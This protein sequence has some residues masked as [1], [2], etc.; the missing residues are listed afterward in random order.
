M[1]QNRSLIIALKCRTRNDRSGTRQRAKFPQ[2]E[3]MKTDESAAQKRNVP[4][5]RALFCPPSRSRR[6]RSRSSP[7]DRPAD[8]PANRP[9]RAPAT[10]AIAPAQSGCT[11]PAGPSH[12]DNKAPSKITPEQARQLFALVDV[13]IKFSSDET[14]LPIKSTVKRQLTTRDAVVKYL[15]EKFNEDEGTKRL[16]RDE[17]ILKKFGLL[18]HDFELKPFLLATPQGADRSLL[19]LQDQ[20]R[21]SAR[22]DRSR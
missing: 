3:S 8:R 19:R 22:L 1:A 6:G 12:S 9:T 16:Q 15:E 17:I 13:L 7:A 4:L 14:G 20:D 18:D 2:R 5:A 21:E 10:P 11:L